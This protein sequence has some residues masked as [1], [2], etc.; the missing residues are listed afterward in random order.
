MAR[1]RSIIPFTGKLGNKIGFERNGNYFF[2]SAPQNVQQTAATRG[3]AKRFG[4]YSRKGRLIRHACYP[5]LDVRCDSTHVNRLNKLLITAAGDHKALKGF[6]FNEHT[7]IDRFLT[8]MP[9]IAANGVLRIPAQDLSPCDR[10]T[11]LEVKITAVCIDFS[12]NRVM[13]TDTHVAIL[14]TGDTFS[15]ISIP[16]QVSKA[17][18]LLLIVQIRGMH[19]DSISCN[20]QYQA[21]N[22]I[23]VMTPS[24]PKRFKVRTHPQRIIRHLPEI[25]RVTVQ[26]PQ[27]LIQRE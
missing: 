1:Q 17:G 12:A 25:G 2:R 13:G 15:G 18:T 26:M 21:A 3:A 11:A 23:A 24:R 4:R 9:E 8:K 16:M 20:K 19:R 10:F 6:R 7:G 22:I 14:D 5:E 27:P